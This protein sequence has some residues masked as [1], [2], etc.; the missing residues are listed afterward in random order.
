MKKKTTS[1]H[2]WLKPLLTGLIV[3]LALSAV[4]LL[5]HWQ[6]TNSIMDAF[7][8]DTNALHDDMNSRVQGYEEAVANVRQLATNQ[9]I[10][11]SDWDSY[12][13]TINLSRYPGLTSVSFSQYVTKAQKA[14]YERQHYRIYPVTDKSEYLPVTYLTPSTG[15]QA[16]FGYDTGITQAD[17]YAW[18]TKARDTGLLQRSNAYNFQATP[19]VAPIPLLFVTVPVYHLN[20]PQATVDDRRASYAGA[21]LATFRIEHLIPALLS[22]EVPGHGFDDIEIYDSTD[23]GAT[24]LYNRVGSRSASSYSLSQAFDVNI[25]NRPMRVKVGRSIVPKDNL[26]SQLVLSA[27]LPISLLAIIIARRGKR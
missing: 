6:S 3:A 16:F 7:H 5:V 4:Y 25:G 19:S 27:I 22:G 2:L 15:R 23:P 9:G 20:A 8:S 10:S 24:V 11:S 12:F 13:R 21:I 17:H 26:I 14:D 18:I 1:V